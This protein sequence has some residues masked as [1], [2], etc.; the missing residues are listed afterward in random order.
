MN[1]HDMVGAVERHD[2]YLA[3]ASEADE[4]AA[5]CTQIETQKTWTEL[6]ATWRSRAARTAADLHCSAKHVWLAKVDLC[7]GTSTGLALSWSMTVADKYRQVAQSLRQRA[8]MPEVAEH[9]AHLLDLSD[10]FDQIACDA[11][12]EDWSD[13]D[14]R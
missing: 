2:Y 10:Q 1:V 8:A 12:K 14:L 7:P 6:A 3:K 4:K 11:D 9:R 13:L 5:G